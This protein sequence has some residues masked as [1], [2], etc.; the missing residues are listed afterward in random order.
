MWRT[1][2]REPR[3][4][5]GRPV[6]DLPLKTR[7]EMMVTVA[8]TVIEMEKSEKCLDLS[9][10]SEVESAGFADEWGKNQE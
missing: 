3:A 5:A 9:C 7:Q 10:V 4:A 2:L 1:D 8:M 6:G